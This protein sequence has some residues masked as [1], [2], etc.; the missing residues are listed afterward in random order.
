MTERKALGVTWI[1]QQ[2]GKDRQQPQAE[3]LH[4]GQHHY[5][6][7]IS[8]AEWDQSL[9]WAGPE[10]P[11]TTKLFFNR[12]DSVCRAYFVK[13]WKPSMRCHQSKAPGDL[14]TEVICH[15]AGEQLPSS[16]RFIRKGHSQWDSNQTCRYDCTSRDVPPSQPLMV[17][18][19]AVPS[20]KPAYFFYLFSASLTFEAIKLQFQ[21]AE[22]NCN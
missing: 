10:R 8:G 13:N 1:Q 3:S 15:L 18:R 9:Y 4:T 22:F 20:R 5:G 21:W 12:E 19:T 2:G 11:A 16:Y 7:Q 6:A 14:A 17:K